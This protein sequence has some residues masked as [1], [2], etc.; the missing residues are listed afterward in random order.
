V[1]F[2]ILVTPMV[3]EQSN[4][5][6]T[7]KDTLAKVVDLVDELMLNEAAVVMG[8]SMHAQRTAVS[9]FE[10]DVTDHNC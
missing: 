6:S 8:I 1:N 2:D 3:P 9:F 5:V 10:R 7:T 4:I